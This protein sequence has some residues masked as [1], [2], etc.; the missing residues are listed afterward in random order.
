MTIQSHEASL[1]GVKSVSLEEPSLLQDFIDDTEDGCDVDYLPANVQGRDG[2]LERYLR[3][4]ITPDL[5]I[6]KPSDL[7]NTFVKA[8][9]E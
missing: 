5:I 4:E 6:E 2:Y 3:G 9:Q 1:K 7:L 8:V